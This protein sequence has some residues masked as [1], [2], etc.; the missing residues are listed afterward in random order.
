MSKMIVVDPIECAGCRTCEMA[1][2]LV[3]HGACGPSISNMRVVEWVRLGITVPMTCLQCEDPICMK[4][5]KTGA[6]TR[7]V[8]T[9][10]M[11]INEDVCVGCK[12]CMLVCPVGAPHYS[13]AVGKMEKCDLCDGDPTCVKVCP[14]GAIKY[15]DAE[16]APGDKRR[17]GASLLVSDMLMKL[18]DYSPA[19][20]TL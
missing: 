6:I 4:A 1:C 3:H 14:T 8:V 7:N 11:L 15:V 19:V 16:D 13:V 12:M 17:D 5:C 18:K 2:S 20:E 10:A 9:G